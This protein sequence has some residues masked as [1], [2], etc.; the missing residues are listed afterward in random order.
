MFDAILQPWPWFI[1]G[2]LIGLAVPILLLTSGK[3]LGI[4]SSFQHLCDLLSVKTSMS[5]LRSPS[6]WKDAWKLVFAAGMI[7]GGF[8]ASHF[9]SADR[10][11]F[12]PADYHSL[13]GA[14]KLAAG[15][16]LVGFGSRYAEGCTSGHAITGLS[17]LQ[18]ASLLAVLGFFGGGLAAAGIT[19]LL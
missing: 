3:A 10:I 9:L 7:L 11:A 18:P 17:S 19:P 5:A 1:A 6:W 13:S 12:L 2:P 15:G 4:S 16:F 8:L 14:M